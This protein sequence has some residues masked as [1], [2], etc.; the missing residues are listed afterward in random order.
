MR[1]VFKRAGLIVCDF[2][3]DHSDYSHSLNVAHHYPGNHLLRS[4]QL[5]KNLQNHVRLCYTFCFVR[6]PLDWYESY[7]RFMQDH[8]W[9]A[10][11][12]IS[13]RTRFG[14][15]QDTWHPL[16]PFEQCADSNFQ[17]FIEKI[18]VL[19]PGALSQMYRGFAAPGQIDFVGKYESMQADLTKLF[20]ILKVDAIHLPKERINASKHQ[21]PV[22]NPDHKKKI[23]ELEWESFERFGYV[24]E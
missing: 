5:H 10:F 20:L 3:R 7:W 21:R 18:I 4:L 16:S 15:R 11:T 2:A 23:V 24:S 12:Q 14:F 9:R 19:A 13:P 8:Q 1:Q 17:K 6:H 22:W